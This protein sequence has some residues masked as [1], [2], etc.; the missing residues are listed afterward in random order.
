[1]SLRHELD[2]PRSRRAQSRE[3][4]TPCW[5]TRMVST[6]ELM[7]QLVGHLSRLGQEQRGALCT[8]Q[9]DSFCSSPSLSFLEG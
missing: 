6:K 1:M 9:I 2:T 8:A 3:T 4:R 5:R 7:V